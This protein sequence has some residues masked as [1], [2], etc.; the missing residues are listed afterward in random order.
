MENIFWTKPISPWKSVAK[1]VIWNYIYIFHDSW[2]CITCS[3]A[4]DCFLSLFFCAP[5]LSSVWSVPLVWKNDDVRNMFKV[6]S[7]Y[8]IS[9]RPFI[10]I[11]CDM[12]YF[13]YV[14]RSIAGRSIAFDSASVR[15]EKE[16]N[17]KKQLYVLVFHHLCLFIWT[18]LWHRFLMHDLVSN[19]IVQTVLHIHIM[20]I[21]I[22]NDN[23][24]NH[25]WNIII[26]NY[27]KPNERK[28]KLAKRI[29]SK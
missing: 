22:I 4:A 19:Y 12:I 25:T 28:C 26:I 16:P 8:Q 11:I 20:N 3:W 10:I 24:N 23:I 27:F 2:L 15:N 9:L 6:W 1:S 14:Q 29:F 17:A 5:R 7:S 18:L 21:G 13:I